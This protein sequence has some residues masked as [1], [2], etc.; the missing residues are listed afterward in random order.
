[1]DDPINRKLEKIRAK[2]YLKNNTLKK[3]QSRLGLIFQIYDLGH[4]TGVIP[5]KINP[6]KLRRKILNKEIF[7]E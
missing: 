6:K 5:L 2:K 1:L 4:E 3:D 7:E